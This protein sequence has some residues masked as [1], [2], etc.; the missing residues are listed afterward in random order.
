MKLPHSI[1]RQLRQ[2]SFKTKESLLRHVTGL[3]AAWNYARGNPC[4]WRKRNAKRESLLGQ[5][6][7]LKASHA[8]H[9][10]SCRQ[11]YLAKINLVEAGKGHNTLAGIPA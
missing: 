10:E 7:G 11:G 9:A 8:R 3:L 4:T 6:R 5:M 1:T 2:I